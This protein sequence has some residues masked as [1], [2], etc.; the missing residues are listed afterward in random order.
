MADVFVAASFLTQRPLAAPSLLLLN[1]LLA[2][3]LV[4]KVTRDRIMRQAEA[5][6]P[7]YGLG[8]HKGYGTGAHMSSIGRLGACP[9]HR[10]TFAPLKTMYPDRAEKARGGPLDPKAAAAAK[11]KKAKQLAPAEQEEEEEEEEE[12]APAQKPRQAAGEASAESAASAAGGGKRR[13]A[14][15]AGAAAGAGAKRKTG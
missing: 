3:S 14:P 10:L 1:K 7:G 5:L 15:A 11:A 12:E 4:A 9:I 13:S 6:W 8:E 2:A